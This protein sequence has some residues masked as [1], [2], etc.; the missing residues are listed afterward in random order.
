MNIALYAGKEDFV[1]QDRIVR[2]LAEFSDA[3][4]MVYR[5]FSGTDIQSP[6]DLTG[7]CTDDLR[8]EFFCHLHRKCSLAGC[9]RTGDDNTFYLF[10]YSVFRKNRIFFIKICHVAE[11]IP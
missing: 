6:V 3:G 11:K 9:R 4:C 2:M 7:V 10:R 8:I 5:I 1:S